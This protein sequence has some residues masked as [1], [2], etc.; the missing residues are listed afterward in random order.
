VYQCL[1]HWVQVTNS[2]PEEGGIVAKLMQHVLGD[3]KPLISQTKLLPSTSNRNPQMSKKA[4]KRKLQEDVDQLLTGQQKFDSNANELVTYRALRVLSGVLMASGGD[5]PQDTFREIQVCIVKLIMQCQQS[6]H[7]SYPIPFS[8][9]EC[10]KAM[11]HVLLCCLLTNSPYVPSPV[12]HAVRLFSA[13]LQDADLKVSSFCQEALA[14]TNSIIHPRSFPQACSAPGPLLLGTSEHPSF[15]GSSPGAHHQSISDS[16]PTSAL[17]QMTSEDDSSQQSILRREASQNE[18]S[19]AYSQIEENTVRYG[20]WQ[21]T[22]EDNNTPSMFLTTAGNKS[23]EESQLLTSDKHTEKSNVSRYENN[24]GSQQEKAVSKTQDLIVTNTDSQTSGIQ[25][26]AS[27]S[28]TPTEQLLNQEGFITENTR[29]TPSSNYNHRTAN[30]GSK[31]NGISLHLMGE[32]PESVET[33]GTSEP[34]RRRTDDNSNVSDEQ[35]LTDNQVVAAPSKD[36]MAGGTEEKEAITFQDTDS[37][38]TATMLA[39]FVDSYPD[40]DEQEIA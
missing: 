37:D 33:L 16:Y 40:S 3:I 7:N 36:H 28:N 22:A 5:I 11:Y 26:T 2:L 29:K 10:R 14:V 6:P 21:G 18:N 23:T 27:S 24:L 1:E 17:N 15:I 34:K 4:K 31:E 8:S 13:G 9:A 30:T 32:E 38:E 25:L 35:L 19:I 12:N 39:T 20:Q